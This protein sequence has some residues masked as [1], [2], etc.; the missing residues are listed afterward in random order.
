M[1]QCKDMPESYTLSNSGDDG[2]G[3]YISES[4][5][6]SDVYTYYRLSDSLHFT[7]T[8]TGNGE[9]LVSDLAQKHIS[10]PIHDTGFNLSV[11]FDND[12][13]L[14][15]NNIARLPGSE[16]LRAQALLDTWRCT[17]ERMAQEMAGLLV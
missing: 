13:N 17:F 4:P 1:T 11:W 14:T 15:G 2:N 16:K 9:G 12:G 10:L 8:P 6:S 7:F 5:T 3:Q